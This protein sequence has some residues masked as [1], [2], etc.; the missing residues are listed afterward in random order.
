MEEYDRLKAAEDK[1]AACLQKEEPFCTSACPFHYDV[2]EFVSRLQRGSFNSAFRTFYNGVAFP[3]L[4]AR[5]CPGYCQKD[6][7][8]GNSDSPIDLPRL[9]QAV[10]AL[11][12]NTKP[13]SYNLPP[14]AGRFAV[15][16]GGVSGLACA[17]RLCQRKYQVTV[18]ERSGS[19]GGELLNQ[20]PPDIVR[21]DIA[22]QFTYEQYELRLNERVAD[23]SPLLA[24]FDAIYIATGAGG[25]SFGLEW[26]GPSPAAS[27]CPKV[28]IGGSLTGADTMHALAQGL[29]AATLLESYLK[30]GV[31]RGAAEHQP[32]RMQLDA[33][34]LQFNP[35]AKIDGPYSKQ[36][37][38]EEAGRCLGCRCDSCKRHCPM[39]K[40]LDKYPLRVKDEVH[41][42]V[43]PGTL[44]H[45]GTV[46][47]R[48]ISTCS[49]CGLCGQVCPQK[50]DLGDFLRTAHQM[51]TTR[52][53]FPWAF[54]HF[55]LRD[56]E[57]ALSPRAAFTGAPTPRPAYVY[58]PGCQVGA[59]EPRY[60]TEAYALLRE[61]EP[62]CGVS[63][64]CCGAP[65]VWAGELPRQE[66]VFASIRQMWQDL[67][68]PTL[69]LA[70]PTCLQMFGEYLPQLPV[71]L[72]S[73]FLWERGVAPRRWSGQKLAAFDPCPLRQR[74]EERQH[75]YALARQAGCE[76]EELPY[77]GQT[78]QC[79]SFGGQ[80]D[81]TDPA[82]ARSLAQQQAGA[83]PLPY[84][85][86]CTNCRDV[87]QKQG[88]SC[89]HVLDLM[90]DLERGTEVA[91]INQRLANREQAKREIITAWFPQRQNELV[92]QV[93][94]L[95]LEISQAVRDKLGRERI[96]VEDAARV[97][98]ACT[99]QDRVC[100]DEISGHLFGCGPAGHITLWVEF[101][102]Q[103]Q[104]YCLHNA[105]Q[106]RMTIDNMED[107]T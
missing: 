18:F 22:Q 94:P 90:L 8:R 89:V 30:T 65:A 73:D 25:D 15:V 91:D 12:A 97:I 86:A 6:C 32:T 52:P 105:Y 4:V 2:R 44:D 20:L 57:H 70:C 10:T 79:C 9:E 37:A 96:L 50:L 67:G 69:I 106:H 84:L 36:Q 48:L 21:A 87:L 62:D 13:T 3:Q 99:A 40:Y 93:L 72:I 95:E 14:R 98:A 100:Q 35:A 75:I 24:H 31:M 81:D 68:Q 29:T 107:R 78:A 102:Q 16:G 28:F 55:W 39:L 101:S 82:F 46:A 41:V 19:L 53:A 45:D 11:A 88:K 59:S 49:Q 60:V 56:M 1:L 23:L 17:L 74:E 58:F 38:V 26:A 33:A 103:G 42:T 5:L 76:L 77:H 61:L 34:A 104:G 66:Q 80:I 54:H 43:Y 51:M 27:S 83:G 63:L 92:E 71:R 64:G 85:V 47:Q 7:P